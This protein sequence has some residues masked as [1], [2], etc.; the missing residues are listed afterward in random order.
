MRNRVTLLE[1]DMIVDSLKRYSG[2]VSCVAR[3]LGITE[4]MLRYKMKKLELQSKK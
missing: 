3:E 2:R 1:R 4:R